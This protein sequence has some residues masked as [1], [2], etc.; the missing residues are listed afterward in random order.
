M[1]RYN[2]LLVIIGFLLL[3]SG[4]KAKETGKVPEIIILPP[5]IRENESVFIN[6]TIKGITVE[7]A[8][9]IDCLDLNINVIENEAWSSQNPWDYYYNQEWVRSDV[10]ENP[11]DILNTLCLQGFDQ[12]GNALFSTG[13]INDA[14]YNVEDWAR[15]KVCPFDF[16]ISV[17]K[18]SY[19]KSEI[20]KCTP[21]KIVK[22]DEVKI[23]ATKESSKEQEKEPELKKRN[24]LVYFPFSGNANDESGN[25]FNVKI[26][27]EQFTQDRFG[28][29][30]SALISDGT[31]RL[32]LDNPVTFTPPYSV[33]LWFK[34]DKPVTSNEVYIISNGGQTNVS[35]G[36]AIWIDPSNTSYCKGDKA[37]PGNSI[38][39][40]VALEK[41]NFRASL[42]TGFTLGE[43][44]HFVGAWDGSTESQHINAYLDGKLI[45]S[46]VC[47]S[48]FSSGQHPPQN[49]TIGAPSNLTKKNFYLRGI[50]DEVIINDYVLSESEVIALY[51]R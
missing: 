12:E 11:R 50:L 36:F 23:T 3:L 33:S 41:A 19:E 8:K 30:D 43:W 31:E 17:K 16:R 4:C 14:F 18:M 24:A 22:T 44:H 39:F 47:T 21:S 38:G 40:G 32:E 37:L 35:Q 27:N 48:E 13:E 5:E 7:Q 25:G 34:I 9:E 42:R 45:N 2:R 49:L 51:Q 20:L 29:Q 6:A 28:N 26:K 15:G 10:G 1:R 46:F